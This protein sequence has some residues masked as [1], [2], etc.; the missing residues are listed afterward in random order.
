MPPLLNVPLAEIVDFL[1]ETGERLALDDNPYL[2]RCL[3]LVAETNP[4]PRRV[5]ENLYRSA[6]ALLSRESLWA[7]V[8]SNFADPAVLDGW[9]AIAA[10]ALERKLRPEPPLGASALG[11][12]DGAP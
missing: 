1:V 2:Q 9:V 3:D 11:L 10:W 12:I 8:E 5:V 7:Q 6:P 4:L